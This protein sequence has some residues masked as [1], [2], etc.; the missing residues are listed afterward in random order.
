[1]NSEN[2]E[3]T[4]RLNRDLATLAQRRAALQKIGLFAAAPLL[5]PA[6]A[7]AATCAKIPYDI[8]GPY[9]AHGTL[10][11]ADFKIVNVLKTSGVVRSDITRSFGVGTMQ[12]QGVPM[13]LR[14]KLKDSRCA[15]LSSHAI[16]LWQCDALGRYSLYSEGVKN[17]NFLRGVQVTDAEGEVSFKSIFPGCYDTAGIVRMPHLHIEVFR[18]IDKATSWTRVVKTSQ[19]ALP[20]DASAAVYNTPGYEGSASNLQ[21][22]SFEEDLVFS[23]G[24]ELQMI[25]MTGDVARGYEGFIE[26]AV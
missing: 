12:A 23:D 8:P 6:V 4:S 1:M 17:E 22:L 2:P 10:N 11:L 9:P 21:N 7:K 3:K 18:S 15:P 20:V 13:N 5:A 16:Y 25:S 14:L 19:L 24:V 26:V